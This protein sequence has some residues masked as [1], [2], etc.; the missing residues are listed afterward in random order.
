MI[1]SDNLTFL[2]VIPD[3]VLDY[4]VENQ[5]AGICDACR[6]L[7]LWADLETANEVNKTTVL[8]GFTVC[9]PCMKDEK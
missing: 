2:E 9:G 7:R 8:V 6:K 1:L 5:I 3:T 4:L